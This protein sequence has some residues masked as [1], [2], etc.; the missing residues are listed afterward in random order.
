MRG[1]WSWPS[2]VVVAPEGLDVDVDIVRGFEACDVVVLF[3]DV[4]WLAWAE[5]DFC[6]C[7]MAEWARKA[8]RKLA[9]KGRCVGMCCWSVSKF[10]ES[11][12]CCDLGGQGVR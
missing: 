8:A 12:E 7:W 2:A 5:G 10:I 1:E 3:V 4:E 6:C 9:K 11:A